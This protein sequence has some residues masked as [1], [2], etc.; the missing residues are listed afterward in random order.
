MRSAADMSAGTTL[1]TSS[2]Q[3]SSGLLNSALPLWRKTSCRLRQTR[4]HREGRL[5]VDQG[6]GGG[7]NRNGC[8]TND[9]DCI[10]ARTRASIAA[11]R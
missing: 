2:R 4:S 7:E 10:T 6:S 5:V 1:G 9:Q 3:S 11:Q 8:P